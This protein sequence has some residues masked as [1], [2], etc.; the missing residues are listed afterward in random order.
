MQRTVRIEA[1]IASYG[2]D[3]CNDEQLPDHTMKARVR[4]VTA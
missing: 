4:N 2:S 1:W 3:H